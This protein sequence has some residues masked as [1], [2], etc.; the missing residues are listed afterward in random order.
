MT[1]L[2]LSPQQVLPWQREHWQQL[3]GLL[4]RDRLP[5]AVLLSGPQGLGKRHFAETLIQRVFCT[6]PL[7]DLACGQC[8]QCALYRSGTHP[9]FMRIE[10]ESAGKAISINAIRQLSEF[11]VITA[12]QQGWKVALVAPVEAMT[13]NAANAFLKTLE[14]PRNKTLLVLIHD[15]LAPVL[16]TIRSRCRV[17]TQNLPSSSV[18]LPWLEEQLGGAVLPLDQ[19]LVR[20][21]GRPLRAFDFAQAN[22]LEEIEKFEHL[23]EQVQAGTLAP[24]SSAA[25]YEKHSLAELLEWMVAYYSRE[26]IRSARGGKQATPRQFLFYDLILSTRKRLESKTNLNPQLILEELF[27]TLRQSNER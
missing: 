10:P 27:L 18:V 6:S 5:H 1:E 22:M 17:L 23:L 20:A 12:H 8:K 2:G 4:V 26:L 16:P 14:E 21:G 11:A 15:Q 25:A 13:L 9:D 19:L 3:L 7:D 24:I